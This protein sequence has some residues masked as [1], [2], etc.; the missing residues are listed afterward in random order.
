MIIKTLSANLTIQLITFATSVLSARILGPVGRGELALVLLY[1]QLVAGIGLL[2]VDRAIAVLGG[3]GELSRPA[4]FIGKLV[5]LLSFPALAIGYAIVSWRITD[6][7][8]ASL[9]TLYLVYVPAMFFFLLVVSLLNGLGDFTRFNL[10]RLW[11]YIMNFILVFA[12]W[13]IRPPLLKLLDW[14]VLANLASVYGVLALA[15]WMLSNVPTS[16]KNLGKASAKGDVI[17]ILALAVVFA[18]PMAL[19]HLCTIAYQIILEHQMGIRA[20]GFFVV[21]FSYSRL[22]SPLGSAIGFHVF[23]LGITGEQHNIARI[24]RQSLVVYLFCGMA[25]G[26]VAG[27]LIPIIFGRE[28]FVETGTVVALLIS[29]LFALLADSM[30]EYLNGRRKG[31]ADAIGRITYLISLAL[32]GGSLVPGLGLLGMAAAVAISDMVRCLYL[33]SR[34]KSETQQANGEFWLLTRMDLSALSHAGK[35]A[36]HGLFAWR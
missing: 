21:F 8:L 23:H 34:V 28:F 33:V 6:A 1:P 25:L 20:L 7:Y 16:D 19:G 27:S 5:L 24:F 17:T 4:T 11:F 15:V 29:S 30:A 9:S 10:T 3:S 2:G 12:I 31:A 14:V 26:L 35:G 22:L 32:L 13:I 18:V 36:L